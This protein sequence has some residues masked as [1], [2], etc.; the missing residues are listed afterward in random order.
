MEMKIR[1]THHYSSRRSAVLA[2]N[3]VSTSHPLASQAG[4]TMLTQ[5]GNA[6]DAAIATAISLTVVEP[7]GTKI[8]QTK[9]VSS[10]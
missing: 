9:I 4:L 6:V 3:M 5:G 10:R 7:T 2:D 1:S 8:E